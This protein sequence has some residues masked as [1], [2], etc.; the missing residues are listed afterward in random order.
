MLV[1][2][3]VFLD[4]VVEVTALSRLESKA[5]I[6]IQNKESTQLIF[7][8]I[9]YHVSLRR[10]SFIG[11]RNIMSRHQSS[12]WNGRRL[13]FQNRR[14]YLGFVCNAAAAV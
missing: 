6:T 10:Q 3:G 1:G 9:T 12:N 2:K 5:P 7:K 13:V 8:G 11:E 4:I 14:K